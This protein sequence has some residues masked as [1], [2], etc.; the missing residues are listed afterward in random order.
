MSD[1]LLL[2]LLWF[3]PLL[4][5]VLVLF[6]PKSAEQ[7]IKGIALAFTIAT[8][9]LTLVAFEAYVTPGS[10][11]ST[12]LS[13]RV[14]NNTLTAD[15]QANDAEQTEG[16]EAGLGEYDLVVRRAWI[17]YFNIQYFLG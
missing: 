5:A 7:S 4:G 1:D 16:N 11:P 2:S 6:V 15:S 10:R 14:K 9:V 8:F 17:P 13:E 3:V 12:P